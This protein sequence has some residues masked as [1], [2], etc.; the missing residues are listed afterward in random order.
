VDWVVLVHIATAAVELLAALLF[1]SLYLRRRSEL[2]YGLAALLGLFAAA[3]GASTLLAAEATHAAALPA[4]RLVGRATFAATL[5]ITLDFAFAFAGRRIAFWPRVGIYTIAIALPATEFATR[6]P[7]D[8]PAHASRWMTSNLD[9]ALGGRGVGVP[10]LLGAIVATGVT[11]YL[12]AQAYLAE[13]D[14]SLP[15]LTGATV[16]AATA[17]ND[18]AA[19]AGLPTAA[20]LTEMGLAAFVVSVATTP[21]ARY[22]A[23]AR[24]LERR[25]QELQTRTRELRRS[26]DD[27][28]KIQ[29]ELLKKEQLAVVGELAAVI[30]HEVRNPLAVIANAGAGLRK[31]AIS[32]EDQDVLLAILDE[33]TSRLNRLVSDLLRYARPVSVQR[34]QIALRDLLERAL[35]LAKAG[36]KTV[37]TDL[38]MEAHEGRLWGDAN[39]LRQVF[40]NLV[41]NAIQAM[42]SG[43]RLTIRVR[44]WNR[45]GTDG[46]GVD[47]IDTG[48]GMDTQVRSRALDPF[49][50]TRPSGTGLGLAIVDRII[51]A[52]GGALDIDSRAGEGTT[53]TVFLP[54]GSASDPPPTRSRG[55]RPVADTRTLQG[56]AGLQPPRGV[57]DVT[58]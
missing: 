47:I 11:L 57:G 51:E 48:E 17:I 7:A 12:T 39:L 6:L 53:V 29:E 34:T 10:M 46:L 56:E 40:D 24:D 28:R 22:A 26:Y 16:F 15:V 45:D 19:A 44:A 9:T 35:A 21:G 52:H 54:H 23:V 41:D 38:Q 25:T 5:A 4:L 33:E 14:G 36:A 58:R 27:L 8:A 49:F 37:E 1:G 50:T 42:S 31:P 32:R 3:C 18:V 43:G 55:A 20:H 2:Q 30:A 13:I